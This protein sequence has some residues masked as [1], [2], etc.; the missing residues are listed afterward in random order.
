MVL[1]L[2]G[3]LLLTNISV[4]KATAVFF[5]ELNVC[6]T[7]VAFSLYMCWESPR[8]LL[9]WLKGVMIFF[10]SLFT[11]KLMACSIFVSFLFHGLLFVTALSYLSAKKDPWSVPWEE[12]IR[13]QFPK[14]CLTASTSLSWTDL[15]LQV[16]VWAEQVMT[17]H[18]CTLG[19]L[20]HQQTHFHWHFLFHPAY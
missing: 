10:P 20:L 4:A 8:T 13:N 11:V 14:S 12:Q 19:F 18:I 3:I 16:R 5:Q 17:Y 6:V 15:Q 9:L 7:R 1:R 2:I